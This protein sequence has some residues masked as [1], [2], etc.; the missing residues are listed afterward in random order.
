MPSSANVR[1]SRCHRVR[2][3]AS[4]VAIQ[5]DERRLEAV[6]KKRVLSGSPC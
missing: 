2:V 5:V 3:L 6:A 1:G 4:D